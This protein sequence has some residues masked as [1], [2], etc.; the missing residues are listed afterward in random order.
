MSMFE[1]IQHS[2]F[3]IHH[4]GSPYLNPFAFQ[5]PRFA[6]DKLI[7]SATD[8]SLPIL[9]ASNDNRCVPG[10]YLL[11]SSM[12][13]RG[14]LVVLAVLVLSATPPPVRDSLQFTDQAGLQVLRGERVDRVTTRVKSRPAA[15]LGPPDDGPRRM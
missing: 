8:L 11:M 15:A 2:T 1:S 5:I 4:S 7:P 14:V 6:R 10:G 12:V 13:G 3:T 9:W